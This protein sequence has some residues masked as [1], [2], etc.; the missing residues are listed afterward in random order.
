MKAVIMAGG[1]GTRLRPLTC[2]QPKPM[3]PIVNRP[4]MEHIIY[5][6]KKHQFDDIYV[7]LFYLAESVENYFNDGRQF[8]VGMKYFTEDQPLGTA[9]SVK[10]IEKYLDQTFLVISGDALTDINLEEAVRFHRAKGATATLILT[11]VENPL[12]YG[13]VITDPDGKVRRFLEKPGWGEVFSDTVNTGIYILEPRIFKYFDSGKAFD[14]SKDLFPLLMAKGEPLY[15][16]V[17]PGYWSDIGNLEQYRQAHYDVLTGKV[18]VSALGRELKPGVWVGD[19]VEVDPEVQ[20]EAPVLLGNY[21]RIEPQTKLGSFT[22]VGD[23]GIIREGSSIKRGV[24]WDHCYVGPNSEIRG[25]VLCHHTHLKGK[26]AVFEGAVLG[27]GVSVGAKTIIKSQVKVWPEK[28]IDSGTILNESLIWAKKS[29]RS[30][31]GDSG[32]SGTVNQEISPELAAKLGAIFG[33]HLK[34]G[35]KTVVSSDNFKASRVLKRALVSGL[36]AAGID[37]YDLGTM[38]T[39]VTRYALVALGAKGGVHLRISPKDPDGVLIEF[40]DAQGMNVDKNTE[41][42]LENSFF[43]EDFPRIAADTMGE[44]TFV[45]QLVEPYLQGIL[46]P[47]I[48]NL[49]INRNFKIVALYEPAGL[50]VILPGLL[51]ELGCR[52]IISNGFSGEMESRPKTIRELMGALNRVAE[53]IQTGQADLGV[54]VDNNAERL[55]V[56]DENGEILKEEQLTGLLTYQILQYKPEAAIPVQVT[57]PHFIEN[58]AKEFHGKVIRTKANPR[59]LM[60]KVVQEK[61]FPA[62]DGKGSY[63]PHFDALFSLIQILEFLAL[64]QISLAEAKQLIPVVERSYQEVDCPW[65]QKGRIMRNLFEENKGREV[66]MTDG[67]KVFHNEGWALVL[68]DAEEPVFRVYSE[69]NTPEEADALSQMYMNRINELQLE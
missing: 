31:F 9:G 15:G 16:Y 20:I 68:P 12:E 64:K 51:E 42:S 33:S 10:N 58:L 50:S 8:G 47:E 56:L 46:S 36:M 4:M 3:V 18:A 67:L 41:R 6:L 11:K 59:S 19:S 43:S 57:A 28:E 32:I 48:Q 14:F 29:S 5:L 69:A 53:D 7:T 1:K 39:P 26:N 55:I 25:A 40:M 35:A 49:I 44:I 60:E 65:D 61:L 54:I 38:T 52:V 23:Y 30:L 34:P 66:E 2:N 27:E 63:H 45:P 62:L 13:V 24:L 37:V 22:V 21:C 17:A